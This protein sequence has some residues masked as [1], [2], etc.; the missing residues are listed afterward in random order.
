[1]NDRA[2]SN[3]D[4]QQQKRSNIW[5][6]PTTEK[7]DGTHSKGGDIGDKVDISS[8]ATA[9]R[10]KLRTSITPTVAGMQTTQ[11]A[12]DISKSTDY[13]S[14]ELTRTGKQQQL[15]QQQQG[16]TNSRRASDNRDASIRKND[17][18]PAKENIRNASSSRDASK[19][20]DVRNKHEQQQRYLPRITKTS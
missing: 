9:S 5:E 20:K 3:R 8:G 17:E 11:V 1:M 2:V 12:D 19:S 6:T 14:R 4:T 7:D 10:K 16:P 15:G 18:G 13:G